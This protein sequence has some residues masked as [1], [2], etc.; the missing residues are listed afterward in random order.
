MKINVRRLMGLLATGLML[1]VIACAT[2]QPAAPAQSAPTQGGATPIPTTKLPPAEA[3]MPTPTPVPAEV[4]KTTT[5]FA[6]GYAELSKSWDDLHDDF[7][8]WRQ[9]LTS[10]EA[11]SVQVAVHGFAGRSAGITVDAGSL[12]RGPMVRELSDSLIEAAEI[13]EE[14]LR[15][16]AEN[17]QPNNGGA[18]ASASSSGNTAAASDEKSDENGAGASAAAG[19]TDS[20]SNGGAG[21]VYEG[22][23]LARSQ[24]SEIQKDVSDRL[25]DL[26]TRTSPD[27][28]EEVNEFSAAVGELNEAWDQFHRNYD[29]FRSAEPNYSAAQRTR[30]INLLV[31][32]FRGI[33]QSARDLPS[34]AGTDDVAD[35]LAE[36]A[37]SEDLL[38]RN[39]RGDLGQPGEFVSNQPATE[40]DSSET[41]TPAP[42]VEGNGNLPPTKPEPVEEESPAF[43]TGGSAGGGTL[44]TGPSAEEEP[45][46][47]DPSVFHAFDAQLV[48]SNTARRKAG[49]LLSKIEEDVSDDGREQVSGFAA[50]HK[51]LVA[52]ISDL[53]DD[54]DEWRSTEGGCDR[55]EVIEALGEFTARFSDL[56]A[57]VRGLPRATF[58]RPMGELLVEAADREHRSVRDLRNA[59]EPFDSSVYDNLDRQRDTSDKLRRQVSSGIDELAS[60]YGLSLSK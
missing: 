3:R 20:S 50:R 35:M 12:P 8:A 32:E 36:A 1:A 46:A 5:D 52:Q 21:S 53:R 33:V 18:A 37:E 6:A 45:S 44:D 4:K 9:G 31:N 42:Q 22:V 15:A 11:S 28:Q 47:A 16:L 30:G 2:P 14:A 10:C 56:T 24:A 49:Q 39:L 48:E 54:Y 38:L 25:D 29:S 7:D 59:W 27:A 19:K 55:A 13:E 23:A 43:G 51:R 40:D 34:A 26:Q 57:D 17:R 60:R 41:S 58:L